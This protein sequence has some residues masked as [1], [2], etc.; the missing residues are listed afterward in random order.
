MAMNEKTPVYHEETDDILGYVT[1]D[2]VSFVA[3][4][5]FGYVISRTPT[6]AEAEAVLREQGAHYLEG[7]WQYF[8]KSERD[9]FPCV[10]YKA[11]D[12]KV[13]VNRTT[14]LGYVDPEVYKQVIL[15][16]PTDNTL[17]KTS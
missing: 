4:T 15:E 13:I 6:V 7:V 8:D 14:E 3:T 10:I 9:W 5:I 11:Y 1:H 16:N 12:Q 17:V 2:G